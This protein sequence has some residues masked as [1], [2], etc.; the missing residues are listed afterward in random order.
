[1]TDRGRLEWALFLSVLLHALL[2]TL[3]PFIRRAQLQIP[4]PKLIDVD[5]F[6]PA[7]KPR[8]V[9]PPAAAVPAQPAPAPPAIPVPKQQIVSPPEQGE[10][11][12][13]SNTRFPATATTR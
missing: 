6:Q 3:L 7:A 8:R 2:L 5:V 4:T 11:K 12:E 9:A 1:M 13:P 10:E